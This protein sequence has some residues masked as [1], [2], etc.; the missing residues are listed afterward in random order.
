LVSLRPCKISRPIDP[1]ATRC[2]NNFSAQSPRESGA[3]F[4]GCGQASPA[5]WMSSERNKKPISRAN[6]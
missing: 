1:K 4:N 5:L 3:N 2:M 6:S